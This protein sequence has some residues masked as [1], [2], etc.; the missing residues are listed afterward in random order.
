MVEP[1]TAKGRE[2]DLYASGDYSFWSSIFEPS[3]E[4]LI[5]A[6]SASV[7]NRVLDVAAGNGN[8]ALAA[9][10]R[11]AIVAALDISPVQ[12]ERGRIRARIEGRLVASVEGDAGGLPFPDGGFDCSLNSFG[13]E[14]AVEEMFRVVRPGG[15]VGITEW[16]GE[17][18]FGGLEELQASPTLGVQGG[19]ASPLWGREDYV[20][21]ALDPSADSI[22][23]H[24]HVISARFE[25]VDSFCNEL[26]RKDSEVHILHQQLSFRQWRRF[27]EELHR[28]AAEWNIA[29]DGSLLLELNYLL[30]VASKRQAA[31][32]GPSSS[33][34]GTSAL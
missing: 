26:Q 18:F 33:P 2:S 28:L 7:G 31:T 12:I 29:G 16:T 15:V 34:L 8:T 14:I 22:D 6:A 27:S 5:E 19:Q 30:T 9:A 32:Y 23:M 10:R 4:P 25:S 11:G 20:R 21:T 24:R 1:G 17:G 13:D 3:S